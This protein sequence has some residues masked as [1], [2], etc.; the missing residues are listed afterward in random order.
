MKYHFLCIDFCLSSEK[1]LLAMGWRATKMAEMYSLVQQY[2]LKSI[3]EDLTY[4][5]IK[6]FYEQ[7]VE[8][9]N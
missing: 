8:H 3:K 9:Y 5:L 4:F 1:A 6:W 7:P 2:V